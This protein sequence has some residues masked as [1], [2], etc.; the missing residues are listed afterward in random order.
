MKKIIQALVAKAVAFQARPDV[1]SVERHAVTAAV[2]V[3]L[4]AVAIGGTQAITVGLVVAAGAAAGRVIWL[5]VA[6]KLASLKA[7]S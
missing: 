2:G 3:V 6:A 5:A 4:A 1:S 7:G